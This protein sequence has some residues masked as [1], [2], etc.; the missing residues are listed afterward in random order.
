MKKT[1][2]RLLPNTIKYLLLFTLESKLK[3]FFFFFFYWF[4]PFQFQRSSATEIYLYITNSMEQAQASH[5][6]SYTHGFTGFAAKLTQH[7]ASQISSE[8][9][10]LI[11]LP[12][13]IYFISEYRYIIKHHIIASKFNDFLEQRCREWFRCFLI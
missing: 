4:L 5:V 1:Q 11:K 9:L 13:F 10:F 7:Q 12:F 6:Y 3:L 2:G 8:P